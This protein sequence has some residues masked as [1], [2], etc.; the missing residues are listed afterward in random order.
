M[1]ILFF[2]ISSHSDNLLSPTRCFAT[3]RCTL[4]GLGYEPCFEVLVDCTVDTD[5]VASSRRFAIA[6]TFQEPLW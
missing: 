1:A 2:V 6:A 5:S 4:F 3:E